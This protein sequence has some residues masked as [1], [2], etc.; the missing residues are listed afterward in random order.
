[1][2]SIN[3]IVTGGT[4]DSVWMGTKDTAMVSEHSVLPEYFKE[5]E[6]NLKFPFK[7][8]FT[9]VCM[10]DSREITEDDRKNMLKNI[11]ESKFTK[12]LVTHGTYTM[13]DTARYLKSNMK[14]KDQKLY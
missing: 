2:N 14:R 10:K 7:F 12:I 6:R 5:L 3:V 9:E 1:M 11:E 13:P 4:I 8:V